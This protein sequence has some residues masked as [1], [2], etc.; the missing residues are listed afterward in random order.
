VQLF[1]Q[2]AAHTALGATPEHDMGPQ[3]IVDAAYEQPLA[4]MAQVASV[5]ASWQTVPTP[6]HWPAAQLHDAVRPA[7]GPRVQA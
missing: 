7:S 6:A 1:V 5:C 2:A 4:S 3:G